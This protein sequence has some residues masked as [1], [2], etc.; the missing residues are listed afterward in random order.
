LKG[1]VTLIDFLKP[2]GISPSNMAPDYNSESGI[3]SRL[4]Q[5]ARGPSKK[6][7]L[8]QDIMTQNVLSVRADQHVLGIMPRICE[9]ELHHIPVVDEQQRLVGIITASDLLAALYTY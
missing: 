6:S 1:I 3:I 7:G 5:L 4:G 2:L 9:T 8:V